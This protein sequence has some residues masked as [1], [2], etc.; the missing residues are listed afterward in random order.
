MMPCF[1]ENPAVASMISALENLADRY[2][3]RGVLTGLENPA[4]GLRL[5]FAALK[6]PVDSAFLLLTPKNPAGRSIM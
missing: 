5:L 3:T 2:I 1:L 6:N 4:V